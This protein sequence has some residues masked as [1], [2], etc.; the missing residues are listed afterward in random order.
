ME[1]T[2]TTGE[3]VS[4]T[5]L[6]DVEP[7]RIPKITE[8]L[9]DDMQDY[10][11]AV[12]FGNFKLEFIQADEPCPYCN[13]YQYG[14]ED[15]EPGLAY[16]YLQ[17]GTPYEER[18]DFAETIK[19]PARRTLESFAKNVESQVRSY[20]ISNPKYIPAASVPTDIAKWYPGYPQLIMPVTRKA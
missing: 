15:Y 14:A 9:P 5:F 8:P 19:I 6:W 3:K 12:F 18:C 2:T 17:D 11:G 7:N 20:L 10:C 16:C 4:V 1:F 13:M